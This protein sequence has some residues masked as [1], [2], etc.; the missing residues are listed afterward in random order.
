MMLVALR[1]EMLEQ[2]RSYRLL[3]VAVVLVLFGLASPV[4]A[5]LTPEIIRLVPGGEELAPLMPQPTVA[6]AV[7][8]YTKNL[9][10]FGIILAILTAMGVVAQE[11]DKGTAALI[12]SKP[13]PRS[14]FL[15]AK[16]A[17]LSLTFLVSIALAG[18]GAYYYTLLLF[19]P[20]DVAGWLA[21]NGLMLLYLLMYVALTLLASTVSRSQMVAAGLAFGFL[22][23]LEIPGVVPGLARYLPSAV[24][25]L[26]SALAL[27]GAGSA[28]AAIAVSLALII[29][30]LLA[31][32]LILERQEL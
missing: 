1:K 31:S 20:L 21:L 4:L 15:A 23:L 26:G 6:D 19:E 18:A 7:G 2:W 17:A 9:V 22:L 3:I 13:M 30:S 14:A 27:G 29:A 16:F 10:Q 32:W 12:L 28:W 25:G 24:L 5:K 8:Q 11:K